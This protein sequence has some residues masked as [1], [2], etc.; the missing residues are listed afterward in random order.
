MSSRTSDKSSD[1]LSGS[2]S[3]DERQCACRCSR[4]SDA[5]PLLMNSCFADCVAKTSHAVYTSLPKTGKPQSGQ[6]WT[7]LASILQTTSTLTY[8][9][10][11]PELKVVALGTGSKCIGKSK[12]SEKGDILNDSHAEVIARRAFLRYLYCNINQA[13]RGDESSIFKY[14]Q[15]CGHFK[16]QPGISF[17]FYSSHT[18]CGDA[19]IFPKEEELCDLGSCILRTDSESCI[20]IKDGS[21]SQNE[22]EEGN[23]SDSL[24][25]SHTGDDA[26]DKTMSKKKK[27]DIY[28]TGAKC[29]PDECKQDPKLP[30]SDYHVLGAVRTK[31]G[32]GDPTLSVSCSDK[33]MRWNSVGIQ[34]ALLSQLLGIP[35]YMESITIGGGCPYSEAALSRAIIK[36]VS[37]ESID[38]PPGYA[39]SFP[40]LF[41]SCIPFPDRKKPSVPRPCSSSIV[42]C[43]VP[44]RQHEVAVEGRRLGVTKKKQ[45]TSAGRLL[46]SKKNLLELFMICSQQQ[47]TNAANSPSDDLKIRSMSYSHFKSRAHDYKKA[48]CSILKATG[49]A[50]TKKPPSL[51]DF[52]CGE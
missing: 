3:A 32:R 13:L 12:M 46:I 49:L 9:H 33:L 14:L 35:I 10:P 25:R 43:S 8:D 20:S 31:P 29:V 34:G 5:V 45:A 51:N 36:R 6:E 1:F 41:Q 26:E 38:L 18:P 50:W 22:A 17:H 42:W 40:Q 7:L 21:D 39:I 44:E 28:R 52:K 47:F 19:S 27:L 2:A 30:G 24:K 37:L 16:L 48:W 23:V 4:K 15:E 11:H